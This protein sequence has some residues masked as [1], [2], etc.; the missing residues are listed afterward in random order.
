MEALTTNLTGEEGAE[1]RFFIRCI[2]NKKGDFNF[3]IFQYDLGIALTGAD[4][5]IEMPHSDERV[6]YWEAQVLAKVSEFK[7][8][9]RSYN[10]GKGKNVGGYPNSYGPYG[11]FEEF[12]GYGVGGYDYYGNYRGA[13]GG[14]KQLNGTH[15]Q[16]GN[17]KK[18]TNFAFE[19]KGKGAAKK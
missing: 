2:T 1:N 8:Q 18:Q 12:E 5:N 3:G 17:T 10:Y 11:Q 13:Q 4:W 16:K 14:G 6:E 15:K 7:T 19:G 9:V